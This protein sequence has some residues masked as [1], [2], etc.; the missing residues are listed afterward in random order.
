MW[1]RLRI[2]SRHESPCC[3]I[4]VCG[5]LAFFGLQEEWKLFRCYPALTALGSIQSHHFINTLE[6]I[7]ICIEQSF[8]WRINGHDW[9]LLHSND[10]D[11]ITWYPLRMILAFPL[12]SSAARQRGLERLRNVQIQGGLGAL[13]LRPTAPPQH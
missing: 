8:Q 7:M 5:L 10:I 2:I 12:L 9:F 6:S 11:G 13:H 3:H 1:V 4:F